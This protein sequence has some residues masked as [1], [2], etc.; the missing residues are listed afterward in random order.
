MLS[1]TYVLLVH[2]NDMYIAYSSTLPGHLSGM[3]SARDF[4]AILPLKS[5]ILNLT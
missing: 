4:P 2:I 3:K 5:T 1:G